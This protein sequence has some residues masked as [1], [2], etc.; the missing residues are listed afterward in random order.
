MRRSGTEGLREGVELLLSCAREQALDQPA[1]QSDVLTSDDP[2]WETVLSLARRHRLRPL[3]W[4]SVA[5]G[6]ISPPSDVRTELKDVSDEL[7]R[8]NLYMTSELVD[9]LDRL[10][11]RGLR[12]LTY[13]GPSLAELAYGD[14]TRRSFVDLDLLVPEGDFREAT[15]VLRAG[16][17]VVEDSFP[18]F[19][20][21]TL[22][23]RDTGLCV[24]LHFRV[25]PERYPFTFPFDR[26]W[27]GRVDVPLCGKAVQTFGPSD[28]LPVLAV[29]GTRHYWIQLEW[30]VS[31]AGL[32]RHE[33]IDW[34][35]VLRISRQRGCDRMVLL[36]LHLSRELLGFSLPERVSTVVE[37]DPIVRRLSDRTVSR[38]VYRDV[39]CS[40]DNRLYHYERYLV[41]LLLMRGLRARGE[42]GVRLGK[43]L[44][45][46]RFGS[47][48]S[49]SEENLQTN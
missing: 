1:G 29:H 6:G 21:K 42:Y 19:G 2:D 13:K 15:D 9:L 4:W 24:D 43:S 36:G 10:E 20:E 3:V 35:R 16:G 31:F 47:T 30:L 41:Q 49:S 22:Q 48:N 8:R 17:Y 46:D 40:R 44:M 7:V 33:P 5:E 18:V 28:L 37:N 14:V 45:T 38:V 39:D 23:E 12:A 27:D 25:T 32:I 34:A 11:E 26:L